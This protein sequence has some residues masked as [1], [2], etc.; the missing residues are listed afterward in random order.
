MSGNRTAVAKCDLAVAITPRFA[1]SGASSTSLEVLRVA[2]LGYVAAAYPAA[3]MGAYVARREKRR[4]SAAFIQG[5][6]TRRF[7]KEILTYAVAVAPNLGWI[8]SHF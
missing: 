3:Q 7:L 1:L 8:R 6:P 2:P 5:A 4:V